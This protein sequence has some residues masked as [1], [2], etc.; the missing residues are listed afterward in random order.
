MMKRRKFIGIAGGTTMA[1]GAIAYLWSDKSNFVRADLKPT[2]NSNASLKPDEQ[3][4]LLLASLAPSGH[5]TQ[6]WFVQSICS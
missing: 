6:P 4:I 3:E 2:D 5:N 1:S